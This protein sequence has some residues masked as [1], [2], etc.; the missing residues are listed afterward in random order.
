MS[1][2]RVVCEHEGAVLLRPQSDRVRANRRVGEHYVDTG[3]AAR[4]DADDDAGLLS[5]CA[6]CGWT[7]HHGSDFLDERR[8]DDHR[9]PDLD[10]H[11]EVALL[12]LDAGEVLR[13]PTSAPQD[14][15]G[16]AMTKARDVRDASGE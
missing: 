4:V 8:V 12:D 16:T 14:E 7:Y 3:H 6:S 11:H 10:E 9:A 13:E 5:V 15:P 2:F 1:E